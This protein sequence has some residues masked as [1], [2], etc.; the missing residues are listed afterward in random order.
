MVTQMEG[1]SSAWL[2]TLPLLALA[3]LWRFIIWLLRGMA[4]AG[5]GAKLVLSYF[6]S[7]FFYHYQ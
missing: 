7:S 6:G 1:K 2:P 5:E 4:V 3:H